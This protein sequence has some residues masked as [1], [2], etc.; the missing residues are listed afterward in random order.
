MTGLFNQFKIVL[1]D[2]KKNYKVI[3]L[4][5][6]LGAHCISNLKKKAKPKVTNMYLIVSTI[7]SLICFFLQKENILIYL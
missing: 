2:V 5:L 3:F 1:T 4:K 7:F 6:L